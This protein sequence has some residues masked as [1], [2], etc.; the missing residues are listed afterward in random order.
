VRVIN[1]KKEQKQEVSQLGFFPLVTHSLMVAMG[2]ATYL[3]APLPMMVAHERLEEPWR[4]GTVVLG[5]V[6]ALLLFQVPLPVVVVTFVFGLFASDAFAKGDKLL[7]LILKSIGVA[8]AVGFGWLLLSAWE[9]KTTAIALWQK[10]IQTFSLKLAESKLTATSQWDLDTLYWLSPFIYLSMM[11]TSLWLSLAM[12]CHFKFL[13]G[14]SGYDSARLRE[15]RLPFYFSL[16]FLLTLASAIFIRKAPWDA[17]TVGF[18]FLATS[19]M[20]IQGCINLSRLL[21]QWK[22]PQ[23]VRTVIYILSAT[24]GSVAVVSFGVLTPFIISKKLKT[25]SLEEKQ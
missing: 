11:V 10:W 2:I 25:I 1:D 16:L 24:L 6:F 14:K 8:A 22:V 17:V 12:G 5:A 7:T 23:G 4:K 3:F 18:Y 13:M 21:N 15:V 19:M 9:E 20:F